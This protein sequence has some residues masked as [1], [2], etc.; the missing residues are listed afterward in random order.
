MNSLHLRKF[1][2]SISR[3]WLVLC[4]FV[5]AVSAQQIPP[6]QN[7][8]ATPLLNDKPTIYITLETADE[9]GPTSI[10][11][12]TSGNDIAKPEGAQ[13]ERPDQK[14]VLWL[15][16]HNNTPWA[17]SF[18]TDSLYIGSAITPTRLC[19]GRP[20]LG[21]RNDIK[22]NIRYEVHSPA[23]FED[24]RIVSKVVPLNRS[25]VFSQSWL[26][27]GGSVLFRVP[28]EQTVGNFA[29]YLPFNYEWEY[30]ERTFRLDEP[31]HRVYFRASDLWAQLQNIKHTQTSRPKALPKPNTNRARVIGNTK[32]VLV[33]GQ[34]Q[35]GDF[36]RLYNQDGTLWYEF[37]YFYDDADGKFEYANVDF[38]PF[39]FHQDHFLLVLKCTEVNDKFFEVIVNEE[40]GLRKYV[41]ANDPILKFETW[42]E[43]VLS[44]FAVNLETK[45]NPL[46][47][48][49][50]SQTRGDFLPKDIKLRPLEIRGDWLKIEWQT[51]QGPRSA[52]K[53]NA[54]GWV[55][56][57]ED[58]N[59]LIEL[60]FF[61]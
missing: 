54:T 50:A 49:P 4:C 12:A 53:K 30:G 32:G 41:K 2:I 28:R 57:K 52:D 3:A 39:A 22:V 5:A 17:I 7:K 51:A 20:I 56:W 58:G 37:S 36:V 24:G 40:T 10:R 15:R 48:A 33:L 43:L 21:L 9:T 47:D 14:A 18:P 8:S 19:D 26:P 1:F 6:C 44:T 13:K 27:S 55:R 46:L 23:R 11:L 35:K 16:L 59:L 61:A 45:T 34:Y 25:D 60:Y 42:Q 38:K 31:Q 29:I